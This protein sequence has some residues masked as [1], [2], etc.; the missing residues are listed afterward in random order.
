MMLS[1]F[2]APSSTGKVE[3]VTMQEDRSAWF[4]TGASLGGV[5]TLFG[6]SN[7]VES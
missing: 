2:C 7:D 3:L 1:S 4:T 5:S 6:E